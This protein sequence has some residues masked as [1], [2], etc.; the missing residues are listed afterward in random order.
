[1]DVGILVTRTCTIG[2]EHAD[3]QLS[4][5]VHISHPRGYERNAQQACG[6][7]ELSLVESDAWLHGIDY[8]TDPQSTEDGRTTTNVIAMGV[9]RH[10]RS[11]RV[12]THAA[13]L[14]ID[15]GLGRSGVDQH[16]SVRSLEENPVTLPHVEERHAQARR[17]RPTGRGVDRPPRHSSKWDEGSRGDHGGGSTVAGNRPQG[18]NREHRAA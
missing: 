2:P 18:G 11:E 15:A 6:P 10:E 3:T 14:I 12:E 1:M 13:Q 9:R 8:L 17:R 5:R 16:R 4:E 7:S